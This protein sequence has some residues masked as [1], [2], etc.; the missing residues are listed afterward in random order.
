MGVPWKIDE[1][2]RLMTFPIGLFGLD[3]LTNID[4][5][6]KIMCSKVYHTAKILRLHNSCQGMR[7]VWDDLA[8]YICI[9]IL[10][11]NR[12]PFLV[13]VAYYVH[14]KRFGRDTNCK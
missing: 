3:K 6:L 4:G 14:S 8:L 5:T 7:R 9:D 13:F 1:P 12:F 11:V 2:A 10:T